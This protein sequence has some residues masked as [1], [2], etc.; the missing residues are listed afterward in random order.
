MVKQGDKMNLKDVEKFLEKKKIPYEIIKHKEVYTSD[1]LAKA[2][3]VSEKSI[4]KTLFFKATGNKFVIAVLPG[5]LAAKFTKIKKALDL[6]KLEFA[7]EKEMKIRSGFKPGAA[8]ALGKFLKILTMADKTLQ[9]SKAMVFPGGDY[10]TSIKVNSLDWFKLEEPEVLE[11][12]VKPSRKK[13]IK[14]NKT[15]KA[16]KKPAK[17]KLIRPLK[18]NP[19]KRLS[20]KGQ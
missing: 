8:P 17:K 7:T 3:K 6:K 5:N 19:L 12:S 14:N 9:K 20:T 10:K 2:C 15:K 18:R 16:I 11:F 13:K 1:K 4:V